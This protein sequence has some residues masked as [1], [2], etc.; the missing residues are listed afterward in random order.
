MPD[1]T[2]GAIIEREIDG[3]KEILLTRRNIP[4][5]EGDWCFPGGHIDSAEPAK[6]AII[7]EVREETGYELVLPEFFRYQDEIIEEKNIHHVVLFFRARASGEA[8][9]QDSEVMEMDWFKL[10]EALS[11][12]LAF[13]HDE[14]IQSLKSEK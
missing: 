14:I 2:V 11:L 13:L 7:R 4:P 6:D 9:K 12:N 3:Q 5:Y 8:N 10:D 1:T